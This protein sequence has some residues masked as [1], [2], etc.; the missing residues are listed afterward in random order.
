MKRYDVIIVGAGLA[1]LSCAIELQKRD[2]KILLLEEN[3]FVGGRTSSW[4]ANG[5]KVESGLHRILGFYDAFPKLLKEADINIE[6]IGIWLNEIQIKLPDGGQSANFAIS[7]LGKP[8]KTLLDSLGNNDFISPAEKLSLSAFFV[9]GIKEYITDPEKLD[10]LSVLQY[11]KKLKLSKN[12]ITKILVPLTAGIFFLPPER[13]SAYALFGLVV[14]YLPTIAKIG[15]AAF[16][17]G[18]TE[19]MSKPLADYIKKKG[20]TV[21]TGKEVSSLVTDADSVIGVIADG[22]EFLADTI[23]L[24]V[25][26][27]AAKE[28]VRKAFPKHK[29]FQDFYKLK[30]MPDVTVQ[31]ELSER[32]LPSDIVTFS[33][34]TAFASYAE[35]SKTTFT[36][37]PGRLSIILTPPEDFINMKA[38]Q[39]IKIVKEEAKRLGI[40]LSTMKRFRVVSRPDHYYALS[41]GNEKYRP[42]QK[43]DIKGLS[44]A[45]DYTKQKYLATMEGAVVSGKLAANTI[46]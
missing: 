17:G 30:T 12:V 33:P 8:I 38:A 39:I 42:L 10:S 14:P 25:H 7:P 5:M 20:G 15:E 41:P 35:Q 28:L 21:K 29:S 40:D 18:M 2:K 9:S 37:S 13:Y 36:H 1:G 19:V 43:T 24:A 16:K 45:G 32:T 4:N 44:L 46:K 22:K 31:I 6:D 26:A 11:A 23:V 27:G 3:K 34:D